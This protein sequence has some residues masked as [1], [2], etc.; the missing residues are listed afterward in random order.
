MRKKEKCREIKIVVKRGQNN[1][2]KRRKK[3]KRKKIR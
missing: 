1:A 2:D 3:N